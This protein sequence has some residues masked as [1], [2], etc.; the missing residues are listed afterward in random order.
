MR[1]HGR[2]QHP[3]TQP[4]LQL[5]LLVGEHPETTPAR[6]IPAIASH[7]IPDALTT[8]ARLCSSWHSLADLH[9]ITTVAT[10]AAAT[11]ATICTMHGTLW[12]GNTFVN[13]DCPA[14]VMFGC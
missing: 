2:R 13:S 8:T 6:R 12:I 7:E 14:S 10:A 1:P 4:L 9:Q 3:L 11:P 5:E